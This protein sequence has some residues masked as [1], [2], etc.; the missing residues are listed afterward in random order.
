MWSYRPREPGGPAVNALGYGGQIVS[1]VPGADAVVV[2]A[3][4]TADPQNPAMQLLREDLLP[5]LSSLRAR[6]E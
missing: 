2:I 3:S 6:K 5:A 4:T 1:I